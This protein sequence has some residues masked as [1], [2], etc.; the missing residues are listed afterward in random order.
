LRSPKPLRR[1]A[2]LAGAIPAAPVQQMASA[3]AAAPSAATPLPQAAAQQGAA[4]AQAADA[5]RIAAQRREDE[6]LQAQA[7][8]RARARAQAD[9][10]AEAQARAQ[11]EARARAQAEA[12]ARAATAR[13]QTYRPPEA[14]NEPEV[15]APARGGNTPTNVASAATVKGGITLNRTQIIGTIGAGRG[16]RALVRLSNGRVITLRIGDRINNGT[17]TA[18]GD[19][20]ITYNRNGRQ[21]QLAVLDGR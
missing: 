12:E 8:A 4:A 3:L 7:E 17:I 9:A 11:A 2:R 19:G 18:I 13:R 14:E 15:A 10:Q 6:Q 5:A 16:S 1:P 21:E 20:K